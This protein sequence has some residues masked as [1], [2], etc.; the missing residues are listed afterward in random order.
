MNFKG[1]LKE[2]DEILESLFSDPISSPQFIVEIGCRNGFLL[3]HAYELIKTQAAGRKSNNPSLE[4]VAFVLE[5]SLIDSIRQ[6]LN[7]IPH[8]IAKISD[9]KS[10]TLKAALYDVGIQ[11]L[12]PILYLEVFSSQM[13]ARHFRDYINLE[14]KF[15]LLQI[16][17]HSLPQDTTSQYRTEIEAFIRENVVDLSQFL[18]AEAFLMEAASAGWFPKIGSS[19]R[20]PKSLPITY[21]TINHFEHRPYSIRPATSDD[22]RRLMYLEEVCWK[23]PLGATELNLLKRIKDYPEGQLVVETNYGIEAAIYSQRVASIDSLY[24][25][26]AKTVETLHDPSGSVVHILAMNVLPESQ[27]QG[28]GSQ[29]LEFMLQKAAVISNV[30]YAAGVTR[31]AN[32][33]GQNNISMEDYIRK[34]TPEGEVQDPVLRMHAQRGAEIRRCIPNYRPEDVENAGYGV[35]TV[36]PLDSRR[37]VIRGPKNVREINPKTEMPDYIG[38]VVDEEILKLLNEG[39]RATYRRNSTF[40][41]LGL[42]SLQLLMLRTVLSEKL[43]MELYPTI[44][45]QYA[46]AEAIIRYIVDNKLNIFKDWLYEVVWQPNPLSE[47]EFLSYDRLWILFADPDCKVALQLKEKLKQNRQYCLM[48]YPGMGYHKVDESTYVLNPLSADDFKTLLNSIPSLSQLEGVVYMWGYNAVPEQTLES[49]DA[50]HQSTISGVVTLAN[51]LAQFTLPKTSKLWIVTHSLNTD[52]TLESLVQWPLSGL[53]KVIREEYSKSQCTYLAL[54]KAEEPDQS[55]QRL[56][57]ELKGNSPEWQIAWRNGQRLVSRMIRTEVKQAQIPHFSPQSTYMVVGGLR[58]LGLMV[59]Q[60]YI[61]HGVKH[62]ILL[63][64]MQISSEAELEIEN[65]KRQGIDIFVYNVNFNDKFS[66]ENVFDQI[67]KHNFPLKGVIH[68]AGMVDHE[69]LMH[70]NWGRFEPIHRLKVAGS[71]MLHQLTADIDLDHFVLFSS[72]LT[73]FVPLGR[74]SHATGN[75]FLDALTHYRNKKG[76]KSLAIDWGPWERRNIEIKHVIYTNLTDRIDM[77]DMNEA[78]KVFE[79]VFFFNKPQI[80]AA[81]IKW[82]KVLHPMSG[83]NLYFNQIAIEQGF[84]SATLELPTH[85]RKK[86]TD[87]D[88]SIAIIGMS[89]RFPGA[90]NLNAFWDLL[91]SSRDPIKEVPR[92]RW[93]IDDYYDPDPDA[94]GKMSSRFGGFLEAIDQF[95][96]QFFSISPKEAETLDP[97]Q[98][99]LMETTWQ[100]LENAAISQEK[101]KGTKASIYVGV[102]NS[103]YGNLLSGKEKTSEFNAYQLTGNVL[104]ATAGR[105]AYFLDVHGQ[106]MA[107]DTATSS[108]AVAIHNACQALRESDCPLAIAAGVNIILSP[109]NS[110]CFTKVRVIAPDGHCKSFDA[111]ANG[112][113]RSEGCGVVIL[114]RLEDALRD[115]D[116]VLAVIKSS[117]INQGGESTD[118]VAP[119]QSAQASLLKEA[120][121]EA[122]IGPEG[123]DYIEAHGSGTQL[124]DRIEVNAINDVYGNKRKGKELLIGSVKSNIGHLEAA[125][126]IAG[127]IKVVLSLQNQLI[128]HNLH[129]KKINPELPLSQIP[130]KVVAGEHLPWLKTQSHV[131]RAGVSSFGFMGTNCHLILEE[132]PTPQPSLSL[133]QDRKCHL[134]TISAKSKEALTEAVENYEKFLETTHSSFADIAYTSNVG[135]DHFTHRIALVASS[136]QEALQKIKEKEYRRG[137]VRTGQGKVAFLFTG[138]G[139]QYSGMGK[140]LYFSNSA[141]KSAIDRCAK[142]VQDKLDVSIFDILFFE[143]QLLNQFLYASLALF[144]IEYALAEMWKSLVVF[145]TYVFGHSIGEFVAAVIA[146][147]ISVEDAIKLILKR[148]ELIQTCAPGAMVAVFASAEV[149]NEFI[150]GRKINIAAYNS[151]SQLTISGES[152]AIEEI[153]LELNQSNIITQRLKISNALHS[154]LLD[155]ILDE[156][157]DFSNKIPFKQPKIPLVSS[158]SGGILT[159]VELNNDYWVHLLREPVQFQKGIETLHQLK[160]DVYLEIGP[161]ATLIEMAKK[162]VNSSDSLW[163]SSL[164]KGKVEWPSLLENIAELYIR[165]VKI[166]WEGLDDPSL[167]SKIVIPTYPFQRELHWAKSLKTISEKTIQTPPIKPVETVDISQPKIL[168]NSILKNEITRIPENQRHSWIT[169]YLQSEVQKALGVTIKIDSN[170]GFFELGMT[171]LMTIEIRQI[172]QNAIGTEEQLS[173]TLLIDY[174]TINKLATF[175]ESKLGATTSVATEQESLKPSN[176]EI[177]KDV[178]I[179]IIGIGCRFPGDANDP[180]SYWKLLMAGTDAI[181][182]IPKERWDIEEYFHPDPNVPGK[183]VSRFGGFI[184]HID[185]FDASFFGISPIEAEGLDPQQ[186]LVLEVTWEALE[187]AGIVPSVLEESSTGVFVGVSNTDYYSLIL[188]SS[189]P[190]DMIDYIATGNALSGVSGR[191]SYTLG[192]QGPCLSLDTACSSSL[193]AIHEACSAL[194]Y[195]ECTLAIAGGVNLILSPEMTCNYSR[196]HLLA[197]DGKCK[198]FDVKADGYVRGEGCGI[199]ILKKLEEAIKDGDP[200]LAT[201]RAAVVNQG[202]SSGGLTVPNRIAQERL[203]KKALNQAKIVPDDLQYIE[204]HGTGTNLGDPIEMGAIVNIFGKER[205]SDNPLYVA[206]VK[207]NIGHLESAA[208]IAGLIKAVLSLQNY[209][210]PKQLHLSA[211]NPKIH[212]NDAPIVIPTES[213]SWKQGPRFAGISSFGFT[214]TNAHVILE[215]GPL[216]LKSERLSHQLITFS[217]S[218]EVLLRNQINT[219]IQYVENHPEQSIA[220][221]A[222]MA[223]TKPAKEFRCFIVAESTQELLSKLKN[224]DFVIRQASK[225]IP[226]IAFLFTGQGSQYLRMGRQLYETQRVF[227]EALDRCANTL[228]KLLGK[229]FLEILFKEDNDRTE[230]DQTGNTQPILFAFEYALAELWKSWGILPD[231]VLGHSAGEYAA[232]TTAG[233]ITLED[234][235]KLIAAR[236]RLMQALPLG[237]AMGA[238]EVVLETV[239]EAITQCG[240]EVDIGAVNGPKQTVISGN[241]ADVLKILDYFKQKDAKVHRLLVSHASHSKLMDPMLDEFLEVAKTIKFYPPQ[242]NVVSNLTGKM[243]GQESIVADYWTKHIRQP[244]MFYESMKTLQEQG[245]ELFLEIGPHPVLVRMGKTSFL[246]GKEIWL[247]SMIRDRDEWKTLWETVGELYLCGAQIDFKHLEDSL[248][249]LEYSLKQRPMHIVT[250]SAKSKQA[251]IEITRNYANFIKDHP[252]VNLQE[253]AFSANTGRSHFNYRTSIVAKTI[254]D[255]AQKLN[256]NEYQIAKLPETP[257]KIAFLFTGGGSETPKMGKV[258]YE[259][260]PVFKEVIDNCIQTVHQELGVSLLDLLFG[261]QDITKTS[262]AQVGLYAFECALAALW[263]SWGVTPAFVCG[264]SAG[265]YAAAVTAGILSLEDGIKLVSARAR[266]VQTL[267]SGGLM[268]AIQADQ[269]VVKKCLEEQNI[270]ADIAAVNGPTQTVISGKTEEINKVHRYFAEKEIKTRNLP[271]SYASHSRLIEPMLEEFLKVTKSINHAPPKLG[272]VSNVTGEVIGKDSLPPGYWAKHIRQSVLFYKSIEQLR[273]QGCEL[274]IEIGPQAVLIGMGQECLIDEKILWLPSFIKNFDPMEK[275]LE[276]LGQVYMQGIPVNWKTFDAPFHMKKITLPTYPFQRTRYWAKVLDQKSGF[277]RGVE[278]LFEVEWEEQP[279]E[280]SKKSMENVVADGSWLLFTDNSPLAKKTF[281]FLEKNNRVCIQVE[282]ADS[283]QVRDAHH[284]KCPPLSREDFKRLW[285]QIKKDNPKLQGILYFWGDGHP[286][287]FE[288]AG[289]KELKKEHEYN[290]GGALTLVQTLAQDLDLGLEIPRLWFV[291][292]GAQ[293]VDKNQKLNLGQAPLV[294]LQRVFDHEYP[295]YHC[296]QVD[297]DFE[298]QDESTEV[299]HLLEEISQEGVESQV[300][301]RNNVRYVQRI[302]TIDKSALQTKQVYQVN[303]DSSYLITGGL[304]GIGLIMAD[305]LISK[306]AKSLILVGRR[307]PDEKTQGLLQELSQKGVRIRHYQVDISVPE[308]VEELLKKIEQEGPTLKGIIHSAGLIED[309]VLSNQNW[310]KFNRVWLP[311]IDGS[312]NLHQ[313]TEQLNI[314]LD[315]MIFFSSI[316]TIIGN[317]GQSNYSAANN[318]MDVLAHY[319]Q[320]RGLTTLS[321]NWGVWEEEGIGTR[322]LEQMTMMRKRFPGILPLKTKQAMESFKAVF[323]SSLPQAILVPLKFKDLTKLPQTW[324]RLFSKLLPTNREEQES[325]EVQPGLLEERLK[326]M[327]PSERLTAIQSYLKE[328]LCQTLRMP[329]DSEI[330]LNKGFFSL[331]MDS[332][333]AQEL[334]RKL[335]RDLGPAFSLPVTLLFNYPNLSRLSE[336]LYKLLDRKAPEKVITTEKRAYQTH[337]VAIV[338]MGCRLPG[339]VEDPQAFWELLNNGQDAICEVPEDH[340]DIEAYYSPDPEALG[341][342]ITRKGGFLKQ[343]DKFDPDFFGISPREAESLDPQQ[344][345]VLEVAWEALERAG[346]APDSLKNSLTGVFVGV[347]TTDYFTELMKKSPPEAIDS[348]YAS[349]NTLSGVSGRLSYFLG[350]QGPCMSID[351]AC[352]SSLVAIH[353]ACQALRLGECSLALAGGVNIVLSADLMVNFSRSH[354]LSSDG[355]CKTFDAKADGY[356]RSE[357]CGIVVLKLLQDALKDRDNIL[358]VIRGSSVNQDGSSSGLTVPNGLAQERVIKQA[359]ENAQ[360]DGSDIQYIEAHGTGTSLGDPIEMNAIAE[361]FRTRPKD[362]NLF[363]GA[364]KSNLGHLECASGVVGIIKTV[365]ALGQ[366][367]IPKNLHFEKLNPNID[368]NKVPVIIPKE[369]IPWP[370][371]QNRRL[372]GVSAFGFTGTIAHVILEEAPP[373]EK[374]EQFLDR[375]CHIVTISAKTED[376][377]KEGIIQFQK[378]LEMHS[379]TNIADI[380]YTLN[381]GRAIFEYKSSIIAKTPFELLEKLRNQKYQIVKTTSKIPKLAYIFPSQISIDLIGLRQIYETHPVFKEALDRC[382]KILDEIFK[383]P[384]FE[385]LNGEE[386]QHSR[387]ANP[388]QIALEYSFAE[389]WKSW[390]VIPTYVLGLGL[391]E[392]SA[393]VVSGNMSVEEGLKEVIAKPEYKGNEALFEQELQKLRDQGCELFLVMG[394]PTAL[395]EAISNQPEKWLYSYDKK[396]DIWEILLESISQIYLKGININWKAFDTPYPRK[397][398]VLPTYPFQRQSYWAKV[399]KQSSI[400]KTSSQ[401]QEKGSLASPENIFLLQELENVAPRKQ[402][403]F[404]KSFLQG[405]IHKL[406]GYSEN[407]VFHGEQNFIQ[408]GMDSLMALDLK[409]QIQEAC[410]NRLSLPSTLII[411]FPTLDRLTHYISSSINSLR[412]ESSSFN[413]QSNEAKNSS[414]I[415]PIQTKGSH[416]PFF[417]VHAIGGDVFDFMDF[418]ESLGTDYPVYGIRARGIEEGETVH[419][420]LEDI[421]HDYIAAIRTIQK[422]GPYVIGG[423]SAGSIIASEIALQ[424]IQ[425][426]EIVDLLACFDLPDILENRAFFNLTSEEVF[427]KF[428]N[429]E[430]G[431]HIN[432]SNEQLHDNMSE[433]IVQSIFDQAKLLKAIPQDLKMNDFWNRYVVFKN[434]LRIIKKYAEEKRGGI[435]LNVKKLCLYDAK[436]GVI[437]LFGFPGEAGKRPEFIPQGTTHRQLFDCNHY[438]I[439]KKPVI[440]TIANYIKTLD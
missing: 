106:C 108:S 173:E 300:A 428:I 321:I 241:E 320:M 43:S 159:E 180:E 30:T 417:L 271:I 96:A 397:K 198:T 13:T 160:T 92:D 238:L 196:S 37:P 439:M 375:S 339:N 50:L 367:S 94:P 39:N 142:A 279:L 7:N 5:E 139:S 350:L 381:T 424:F 131:R 415:V 166:Y 138:Q 360:V 178:A 265:E 328:K 259:T 326:G 197:P 116:Q 114:K 119:S 70:M 310:D 163:L 357:G 122:H 100:A 189:D 188:K 31:C 61:E 227:R 396:H 213:L 382:A 137:E 421:V 144:S 134:L 187:R 399:L 151:P 59:A 276:S 317:P 369:S 72:I 359:M 69:L 6:D 244:V 47:T 423:W 19:Y 130:A 319:R 315:F 95:D 392:F 51:V 21:L 83:E 431:I 4:V 153:I 177:K 121:S 306:G 435:L 384:F 370:R 84:S 167:R 338:G 126:G 28:L 235:L 97:Q 292:R 76:L 192:L 296:V 149:V 262:F 412:T 281:E 403:E 243:I 46:S 141:F 54:D 182:E 232:A 62:L 291:T 68:A 341:K 240:V 374:T 304:T 16:Q 247:P 368:F 353:Q 87:S 117:F 66:F 358:G 42:K 293:P 372:A 303:S 438:T 8:R 252:D 228:D 378:Y 325:E 322:I 132:S 318:F 191:I 413:N 352:A 409:I 311:K 436:V 205:A 12:K 133:L 387:Y 183:M 85:S 156:F 373:S 103:D 411:E 329:L 17:F 275:L 299:T 52:G 255:L 214:G 26:Q 337:P 164:K 175:L 425:E 53:C 201:I 267:P 202:G 419:Q 332:L 162:C 224:N 123:I 14:N 2:F 258:L 91:V 154:A 67:K 60:W 416:I 102:S 312:W 145:P 3:K 35:L 408:S 245:C 330:D 371:S 211:L 362:K 111:S 290:C 172:L 63:D 10:Q 98:R 331:G 347:S 250:M 277:V 334:K 185:E 230:L 200:I 80:S 207:T 24:T 364:V 288:A 127:F 147:V 146:D 157:R 184:S 434:N 15:G 427:L 269:E 286:V 246:E 380:A 203:L 348:Y 376:A 386:I 174:P 301:W 266:L 402:E 104:S 333:L 308:A 129:L 179:A 217:E 225:K 280:I 363:V 274:F 433:S 343:I 405:I 150:K 395:L 349:G 216:R 278:T 18:T 344:R 73:D 109:R 361:V 264:H 143:E 81:V 220:A 41:D 215:E 242:T 74:A 342:I 356:V 340:W 273:A 193:V 29:L 295:D 165:G 36:Y 400:V 218:S 190:Q 222:W 58:P 79:N 389:L 336:Y 324:K 437:E 257:P 268:A 398:V 206:S 323:G 313:Q 125:S 20:H 239:K 40:T 233:L 128:P 418:S 107:I 254:Q 38:A 391:G 82:P 390:G 49:I 260:Q 25:L 229:P 327:K 176:V 152:E 140:Q 194:R 305:F 135:R 284:Y 404:I 136:L 283:Y 212:L 23:K 110:I 440:E 432:I 71:W 430:M 422:K 383:K 124:G 45:L 401:I 385:V 282:A 335:R 237:G 113:C 155:P 221:L 168:Q 388:A 75:S 195:G 105:L 302:K 171:S 65:Y 261:E 90:P 86:K 314:K 48:V 44:F 27:N 158:L 120:L 366:E 289:L 55:A 22:L 316:A 148:S 365:L 251:L 226:K 407:K 354:M 93:N 263:K 231:Y 78:F 298:H 294:G 208:G 115:G 210:I 88:G 429:L 223:N 56:L 234:G 345:L 346:C 414:L 309:A 253:L 256:N 420:N 236:A 410:G 351:A 248:L 34:L 209:T 219:Y 307:Q 426:G 377:L 393:A 64:E 118:L 406:L 99:I 112:I 285:D 169:A 33:P 32:Y 355:H 272:L 9:A 11:D 161:Q 394:S 379:E 199:L 204:A 181:Q 186:R 101:I 89:C 77:L 1:Y 57:N 170:R 287:D 270:Q 297:F 249:P